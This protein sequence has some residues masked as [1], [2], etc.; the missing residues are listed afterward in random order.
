[1]LHYH[2]VSS[3]NANFHDISFKF[4]YSRT[5]GMTEHGGIGFNLW[6]LHPHKHTQMTTH[7]SPNKH[8]LQSY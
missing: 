7:S 5:P 3:E 6:F 1:M 4:F 2:Q 8:I